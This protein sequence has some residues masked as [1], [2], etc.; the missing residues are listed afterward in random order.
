MLQQAWRSVCDLADG[1]LQLAYPPICWTC[2]TLQPQLRQGVC[3]KCRE[4]LTADPLPACPRCSSTVGPFA[5]L[6]GGCGQ[7]RSESFAFDQALRLGPYDP[8]WR[9]VILRMKHGWSLA[10]VVGRL[11]AQQLAPRLGPLRPQAVVAVPLHWRRRWQRGFNQ[12]EV[13]AQAL[14]R[15]LRA[16]SAPYLLRRIRATAQQSA[17]TPGQRRANV[18][19]AFLARTDPSLAGQT[20]VLVDD[21]LTTGATAHEAARALRVLKPA[22]IVV[23]VVAH[24]R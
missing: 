20:I 14:A 15:E 1:L 8:T 13:L 21:V 2:Q 17:L 4:R 3:P 19:G 24:G 9:E 16:R 10:E 5:I 12:S 22:R 11:W 6:E 23:A 7:C 18:H